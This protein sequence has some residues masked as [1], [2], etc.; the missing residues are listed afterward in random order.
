MDV[1]CVGAIATA[2]LI[3]TYPPSKELRGESVK[4]RLKTVNEAY[5]RRLQS[6]EVATAGII[7]AFRHNCRKAATGSG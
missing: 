3:K 6:F 4:I 2:P 5:T 7:K 1:G